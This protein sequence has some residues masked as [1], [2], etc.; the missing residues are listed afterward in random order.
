[1]V[2]VHC[3]NDLSTLGVEMIRFSK[4]SESEGAIEFECHENSEDKM[5]VYVCDFE[6]ETF[7]FEIMV[8]HG[9]STVILDKTMTL[10]L[11]SWLQKNLAAKEK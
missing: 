7:A 9:E 5:E 1:M 4:S 11:I 3:G 8:E 2:V 6:D 10:E